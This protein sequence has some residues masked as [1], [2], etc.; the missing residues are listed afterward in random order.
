[1]T[2]LIFTEII[3]AGN[4]SFI[5]NS[6]VGILHGLQDTCFS[7]FGFLTPIFIQK[8]VG[9]NPYLIDSWNTVWIIN[10][11]LAFA[12]SLFY[13]LFGSSEEQ[14]WEIEDEKE[15]GLENP[16]FEEEEDEIDQKTEE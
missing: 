15:E 16:G 7:S 3:R 13:G 14:N 5:L 6:F 4:Y 9:E 11:A 10:G 12:A 8:C 2:F 1:M